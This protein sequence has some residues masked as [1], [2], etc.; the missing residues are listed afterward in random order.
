LLRRQ[1]IN[2]SQKNQESAQ[3]LLQTPWHP[4]KAQINLQPIKYKLC[5]FLVTHSNLTLAFHT[6]VF[7]IRICLIRDSSHQK[8]KLIKQYIQKFH[9]K[10][11]DVF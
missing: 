9:F 4:M 11:L 3:I 1:I 5:L 8:R 6:Q 2:L 7:A 10:C